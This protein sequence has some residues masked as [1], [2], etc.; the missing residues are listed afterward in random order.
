[1]SNPSI[2]NITPLISISTAQTVPLLLASVAVEELALAHLVNAEAEGLQLVLGT[3]TPTS[4]T[5]APA[6]VSV[7]NFLAVNS[8]IRRTLHDVIKKEILLEFKFENVL[9]LIA[10][11]AAAGGTPSGPVSLVSRNF[12]SIVSAGTV[13]GSDLQI[14]ASFFVD[15]NGNPI[16]SFPTTFNYF[17]LFINGMIQENGVALVTPSQLTIKGGSVLDTGD[18]IALAFI[19]SV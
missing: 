12:F 6:E 5:L 11:G 9:D 7:S 15:D 17:N 4:T 18:P 2:P 16:T 13:L 8:D 14:P 19:I 3:L 10:S 1:M